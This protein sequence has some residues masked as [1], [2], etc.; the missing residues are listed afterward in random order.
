MYNKVLSIQVNNL[1]VQAEGIVCLNAGGNIEVGMKNGKK[2]KFVQHAFSVEPA[3]G[4]PAPALMLLA[5]ESSGIGVP[6]LYVHDGRKPRTCYVLRY[7]VRDLDRIRQRSIYLGPLGA[8]ERERLQQALEV[9]FNPDRMKECTLDSLEKKVHMAQDE[10]KAVMKSSRALAED[11]GY[12]L[13]GRT[14]YRRGAVGVPV[15][16]Q[17]RRVSW[18]LGYLRAMQSFNDLQKDVLERTYA[19]AAAV[20]KLLA[21][22][23]ARAYL[24]SA[25]APPHSRLLK[26]EATLASHSKNLD[27]IRTVHCRIAEHL[28]SLSPRQAA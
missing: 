17:G 26:Y 23:S 20:L 19:V 3:R 21:F 25:T 4:L 6:K 15:Y 22:L 24:R 5:A 13:K 10:F 27:M 16:L 1:G 11:C 28:D 7:R 18:S 9:V 2:T 14:L 12:A 8:T